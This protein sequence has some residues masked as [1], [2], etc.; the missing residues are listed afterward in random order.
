MANN[1]TVTLTVR[2]KNLAGRT[3]NELKAGV[4]GLRDSVFSL[5]G[6]MAGL[7]ASL[8]ATALGGF[9]VSVNREYGKLQSQLRTFEGDRAKAVF[10]DLAQF[11]AETPFQIGEVVKA[12]IT[13]RSAG[14]QPTQE[15]MRLMG[16]HAAAFGGSITDMAE[17]VRAATTGEMERLKTFGV[18]AR[19][20]GSQIA[21][22]FNG[23]TK[24]IGRD[25]QSITKYLE[26]LSRANF[27]GGMERQSK[28]LDGALS[29]LM[30]SLESLG[31]AIGDAGLTEWLVEVTRKLTAWVASLGTS[32][33]QLRLVVRTF[34]EF[35]G[36][37]GSFVGGAGKV[38]LTTWQLLQIGTGELVV[39]FQGLWQVVKFGAWD[40]VRAVGEL[41]KS[42]GLVLSLLPGMSGMAERA[43]S[44]GDRLQSM[45][46]QGKLAAV[47][48]HRAV[49]AGF[50]ATVEEIM[51]AADDGARR[52]RKPAAGAGGGLKQT[53][54]AA[55]AG[56]SS[57]STEA[58]KKQREAFFEAFEQRAALLEAAADLG[59]VNAGALLALEASL[60]QQ[61]RA[62][63]LSVEER[64][65]LLKTLKSVRDL[66]GE[67][68]VRT[69]AEEMA[70]LGGPAKLP[71]TPDFKN[72]EAEALKTAKGV[73]VG[74]EGTWLSK[75]G[76]AMGDAVKEG[77]RLDHVIANMTFN[78]LKAFG[79]AVSGAFEAWVTGSANAGQA[80]ASAMLGALGSVAAGFGQF[81]MA[82]ATG[83]IA[84]GIAA[85]S[86][87]LTAPMAA[88]HF[89]SAALYTAGATAMFAL[90]GALS[91]LGARAMGSGGGR[92]GAGG[93]DSA[94]AEASQ[95]E[96]TLNIEGDVLDMSNPD[97]EAALTR[98]L[99][100][101]SGR[102]VTVRRR[103]K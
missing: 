4:K 87:P 3:L 64:I 2:A 89:K 76:K 27:A 47:R 102:R 52:R 73:K 26:D 70:A 72:A 58:A 97:T 42:I 51:G 80:F 91:G 65:R 67:H 36:A 21:A 6:A 1:G 49:R 74:G 11:A 66:R 44:A 32:D 83:E 23:T 61:L 86:N 38:M 103:R 59:Q 100:N 14:I 39:G 50:D 90:G 7:S 62:G 85:A 15:S 30:D 81:F 93:R 34:I 22:T 79:D 69:A 43:L 41:A 46:T 68:G 10:N 94:L 33:R 18:V 82:S 84:K 56:G 98:A 8:T 75:L 25:A 99:E 20:Q 28:T 9:L 35:A 78:T 45:A 5:R 60:E 88:G 55:A 19:L 53:G 17:A 96:M 77:E 13:L 63:N 71:G 16:D 54:G 12:F 40:V 48:D 95:R 29:N 31:R 37:I 57:F 92:G 101:I 24:V